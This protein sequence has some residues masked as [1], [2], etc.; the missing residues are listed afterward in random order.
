MTALIIAG[1]L[2]MHT[3]SV[4]HTLPAVGH[5]MTAPA[6]SE[7]APAQHVDAST[8]AISSASAAAPSSMGMPATDH[9]VTTAGNVCAS[10]ACGNGMP[11]HA[12]QM[13]LCVLALLAVALVL[14]TPRVHGWLLT[15]AVRAMSLRTVIA[16]LPHPR[17]PSLHVL[18]IS[19]T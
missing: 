13:M 4:G 6:T 5:G 2:G 18:S 1:L 17:P 10:D 19:R 11:A 15:R 7:H 3:L 9:P 12:M 14:L 16:T 8:T